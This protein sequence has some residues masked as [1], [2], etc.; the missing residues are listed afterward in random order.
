MIYHKMNLFLGRSNYVSN[1]MIEIVTKRYDELCHKISRSSSPLKMDSVDIIFQHRLRLSSLCF[2]N[3]KVC[4]FDFYLDF[5]TKFTVVYVYWPVIRELQLIWQ[6]ANTRLCMHL[7]FVNLGAKSQ[8]NNFDDHRLET[9]CP[10]HT[11]D[12]LSLILQN[13]RLFSAIL[14]VSP[15]ALD[16]QS[17]D[18][19]E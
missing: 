13:P 4:N 11:S 17:F 15:M 14:D 18:G 7:P 19:K 1:N 6:N 9:L 10:Q 2:F 12:R 5:F 8:P 3:K 16:R